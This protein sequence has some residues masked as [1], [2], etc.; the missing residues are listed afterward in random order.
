MTAENNHAIAIASLSNWLKI[1]RQFFF[2]LTNEKQNQNL[3]HLARAIFFFIAPCTYD[4]SRAL[5]KFQV[6]PWS[7][8]WFILLFAPIV[9]GWSNCA[10][11]LTFRQ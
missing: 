11:V 9:N 6:I 10:L 2:F 3:S 1:L 5:S 4:F 7:S 8:N